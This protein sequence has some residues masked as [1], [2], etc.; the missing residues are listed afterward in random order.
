MNP[1][2]FISVKFV[3]LAVV[4]FFL[5]VYWV[6]NFLILYHLAR[7]GVGVQPKKFAAIF[8]LGSISLFFMSVLLFADLDMNSLK[9]QLAEIS[10]SALNFTY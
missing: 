6:F 7:F 1:A 3:S 5:L 2:D 4:L 9:N 8:L 10:N